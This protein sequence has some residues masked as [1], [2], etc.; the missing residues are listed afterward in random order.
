MVS[1]Q[2]KEASVHM[3][4]ISQD[5]PPKFDERMAKMA[6]AQRILMEEC[7]NLR[8]ALT[9]LAHNMIQATVP[10][11]TTTM[12]EQERQPEAPLPQ[13]VGLH[14]SAPVARIITQEEMQR[15]VA[16]I[17]R[18][19]E[20][21]GRFR[22]RTPYPR[23]VED[24]L[25]PTNFKQPDFQKFKGDEY[26]EE[27][28]VH[29]ITSIENFSTIPQYCLRL[30]RSSLIGRAFRWY[31]DLAPESIRTWEQMQDTFISNFFSSKYDVTI[32][33]LAYV[34]QKKKKNKTMEKFIDKWKTL[35]ASCKQLPEEKK[36][37]NMCLNSMELRIAFGLTSADIKTF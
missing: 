23:K 16:D 17:I 2:S 20:Y 4:G 19:C 30:F 35:G 9:T 21:T 1:S 36:Q 31:S 24:V 29:F 25:F 13:K 12:N 11:I 15:M 5:P 26:P 14:G 10:P 18:D 22:Y 34:R 32:A 3:T 33:K 6:E 7:R 8:E 37:V 27:H 28:P